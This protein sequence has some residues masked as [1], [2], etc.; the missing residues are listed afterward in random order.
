[1]NG[2]LRKVLALL[3]ILVTLASCVAVAEVEEKITPK[4]EEMVIAV[5]ESLLTRY[6]SST[7]AM[8]KAGASYSIDDTS[9]ATVNSKGY[10]RGVAPGECTLTV[11]S[12][13]NTSVSATIKVRIIVPLK[14]ITLSV[15][16][17]TVPVG[18]TMQIDY[19]FVPEN[20]T[21]AKVLFES[22]KE[23]IA[24]ASDTGLIRAKKRGQFT[25][26][27][28]SEDGKVKTTLKLTAV[29]MPKAIDLSAKEY[30]VAVGKKIKLNAYVRPDDTDNKAVTW[31]SSDESIATIDSKGNVTGVQP[32]D[33]TITATSQADGSVAA[34]A[35]LHSVLPVQSIAFSKTR[36]D[37]PCGETVQLTAAVL[38]E[39]ATNRKVKYSSLAPRICTVDEN[40]LVTTLNGGE[41]I[42]KAET[43]DGSELSATVVVR[44]IV[45]VEEVYFFDSDCRVEAGGHAFVQPKVKPTGATL[46]SMTW[47]S[48]DDSI[49]TVSSVGGRVRIQGHRWGRC[50]VSGT[51][52]DGKH[53]AS[54]NVNVGLLWTPVTVQSVA[55]SGDDFV[56]TLYNQSNM[57]MTGVTVY[58]ADK[59]GSITSVAVDVD[60]PAG[61]TLEGVKV[62]PGVKIRGASAAV[63]GWQTDDGYYTN[64]GEVRNTYRMSPGFMQWKSTKK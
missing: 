2:M 45:P 29:Q 15:P 25:I 40:G 14:K 16:E 49:A 18:K 47:M 35:V 58:L 6:S 23:D 46:E 43:T 52:Y 54:I 27:A 13:H 59:N 37:V 7:P 32:G 33:V 55:A 1:M 24:T 56:L 11:T 12:K 4:Y 30:N 20:A 44:S 34:R 31:S 5:G 28:K 41:A 64:S 61:A 39:T 21:G 38:P 3:M 51:S 60:M 10:V 62:S 63:A 50:T 53:T 22:N 17:K 42:I 57:H 26:T 9:I 48:S 19:S 36:Y 8:K